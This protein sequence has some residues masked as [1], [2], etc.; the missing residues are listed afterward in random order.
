[1]TDNDQHGIDKDGLPGKTQKRWGNS[2]HRLAGIRTS[3]LW[4]LFFA[5]VTALW[6]L[7]GEIVIGGQ[8]SDD[9]TAAKAGGISSSQARG[10][11]PKKLFAVQT[12]L[13]TA[14][15]RDASLVLRGRTE[16]DA[17]VSVMAETSGVVQRTP[18]KKGS[19]VEKG[20]LLCELEPAARAAT[21]AQYEA[22]LAKAM[23]DSQASA[24]LVKRGYAGKLKV[25]ND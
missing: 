11:A 24:K 3:Y 9:M 16:A 12:R 8:K 23:A 18:V 5:G 4:A 10:A 2:D 6:L 14:R 15:P 19:F 17:K 25:S 13:I 7:T 21:V 20:T 1:M 22:A